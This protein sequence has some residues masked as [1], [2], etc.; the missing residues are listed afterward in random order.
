MGHK[1][2]Y[3]EIKK[4]LDDLYKRLREETGEHGLEIVSCIVDYEIELEKYCN[5]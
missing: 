2:E 1:E 5:N 4:K 3:K